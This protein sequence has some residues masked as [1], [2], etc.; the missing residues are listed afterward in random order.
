[1]ETDKKTL[2]MNYR[3]GTSDQIIT[4]DVDFYVADSKPD[5]VK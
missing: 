3:N 1:M 5:I 4:V 2:H